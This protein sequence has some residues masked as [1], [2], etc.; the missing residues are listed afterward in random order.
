MSAVEPRR[1]AIDWQQVHARLARATAATEQALRLS[2]ER[3]RAVMAE[4]ARALAQ[5]PAAAAPAGA[6]LQLVVFTLANERYAVET[7]HVRE[8]VRLIDFTPLP[9]APDFLVGVMNLRGHIVAVIDLRKF[10]GVAARGLTDLAR[11]LVLGHDRAEFGVLADSAS[12]VAAL[13]LDR[14]LEAPASVAGVAREYLRG[15]TADALIVL[16]G[17]ALLQDPRL[18]IDQGDETGA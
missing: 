16:D 18:Y 11:V 8:V 15:V 13:P 2:P 12:E 1:D 10:F 5:V 14:M 9:G 4:R 6:T 17:A 3:A 7:C